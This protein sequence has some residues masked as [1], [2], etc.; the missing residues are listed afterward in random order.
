MTPHRS[1][2]IAH[3][4]N[5][6]KVTSIFTSDEACRRYIRDHPEEGVLAT[7]GNVTF[8]AL[9]ADMEIPAPRAVRENRYHLSKR[10]KS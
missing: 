9:M 2:F 7:E 6:I 8:L 1:I 3:G 10:R 5:Y 4:G